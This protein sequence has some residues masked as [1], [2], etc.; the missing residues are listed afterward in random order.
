MRPSMTPGPRTGSI[1][2]TTIDSVMDSVSQERWSMAMSMILWIKHCC[3][4]GNEIDFKSLESYWGHY[5]KG[6]HL[7][8]DSWRSLR[9]EEAW[10]MSM[11]EIWCA[12][13]QQG[14]DAGCFAL[15]SNLL[16]K[17][18]LS[19]TWPL[20]LWCWSAFSSMR[21]PPDKCGLPW[22]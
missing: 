11:S 5:L 7:T 15:T 21:C 17:S 14:Y 22:L 9:S 16:L 10:K 20:I 2:H 3:K 1:V 8:L 19:L 12:L 4:A 6:S 18:G 13:Q